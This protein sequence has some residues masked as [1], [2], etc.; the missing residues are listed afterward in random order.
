MC[1][2]LG[3][4]SYCGT[5]GWCVKHVKCGV[6]I[7]FVVAEGETPKR[8]V[9]DP[10]IHSLIAAPTSKQDNH[11]QADHYQ[12]I[13]RRRCSEKLMSVTL[14]SSRRSWAL[15]PRKSLALLL[16]YLY[17]HTYK[18]SAYRKEQARNQY[19]KNALF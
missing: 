2:G 6:P 12:I 5:C 4:F 1:C 15:L 13:A 3:V 8:K 14:Q 10:S 19:A 17:A 11:P 16:L 18:P 7:V 9:E